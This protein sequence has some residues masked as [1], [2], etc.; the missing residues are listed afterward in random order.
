MPFQ[1]LPKPSLSQAE[2]NVRA[3]LQHFEENQSSLDLTDAIAF[4]NFPLFREEDNLLIAQLVLI[5]PWHGVLLISTSSFLPSNEPN[6]NEKLEQLEGAFSQ[7]FSRLVKYPKLRNGRAQLS[8]PIDAVLWIPESDSPGAAPVV[9]GTPAINEHLR[10]QKTERKI[11]S[12]VFDELISVLDGSK[13]L[14]RAK[15]RKTAG[16]SSTSKISLVAQL[17]EEIRRFDRD[18]RVA[19]MTEVMGTQRIRGLAG[20]GKTVVLAMKAALTAIREPDARIAVTFYTKS[21]YQHLK[22]LI[23]RFYRLHEDRDPDWKKLQV[24]HAWGGQTAAGLYH[25]AATTFGHRAITY[26]VAASHSPNQPFAYAC[27]NLIQDPGVRDLFDYVFVDEAQDFP[28]EFM[29]L[30]LQLAREE[31]LVIAYDAFQTIFDVEA[32]T[33]SSLFGSDETGDSLVTFDE[34]IILHKCYRNPREILVC[35]HA[36]G[37]GIYGPRIVQML[38]SKEHWDDLG[39]VVTSGDLVSG[40]RI[41]V[42]RP[43]E[44][45]PSSISKQ[46]S[47][48]QLVSMEVFSSLTDEVAHVVRKITHDIRHEGIAPEDIM[49]ICADDRNAKGYF[50]ILETSLLQAEIQTNNLQDDSYSIRD[51]QTEGKVTLATVYKA[52]GNEAY[53]V[54]LMGIDGIFSSRSPKNRNRAFTAMTRAKGW[55]SISGIGSAA[56]NFAIEL[57]LAKTN[58]PGLAFEYPKPEEL[59][60]MKRDLSKIAPDEVDEAISRLAN[61]MEPEE[62]EQLLMRR[63]REVRSRKK[64]KKKI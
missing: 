17:E 18:Q 31:K 10:E 56:E 30:A 35:A 13:V 28:P 37:F 23:T 1:I 2:P 53:V 20:S 64:P 61:D 22:Q 55:L 39:Y 6:S 25:T 32:P 15:E 52:K 40:Q 36:I 59:L 26:G 4:F 49:V 19:Y 29:K 5:S 51:F 8:F 24:L 38:E 16:F 50:K 7:I 47:A 3:L 12:G 48:D 54:H 45:S 41:K 21:L 43:E 57:N 63:L 27:A 46:Q 11:D 42:D 44:N 62:L 34:D 60:V 14:I 33:A 58:L 9:I